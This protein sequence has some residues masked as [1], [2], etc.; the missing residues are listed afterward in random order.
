MKSS[1]EQGS[2]IWRIPGDIGS[3]RKSPIISSLIKP[4]V[5]LL[6]VSHCG[7]SSNICSQFLLFPFYSPSFSLIGPMGCRGIENFLVHPGWLFPVSRLSVVPNDLIDDSHQNGG[8]KIMKR[9]ERRRRKERGAS[10]W[11]LITQHSK[12]CSNMRPHGGKR[13][14]N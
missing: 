2:K 9:E 12:L 7:V 13:S 4:V 6:F 8:R 10:Y 1:D 3:R 11:M 14:T 5:L